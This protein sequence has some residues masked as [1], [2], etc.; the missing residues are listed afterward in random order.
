VDRIEY[1]IDGKQV[2]AHEFVT[3]SSR[4]LELLASLHPTG[5]FDPLIADLRT[6]STIEAFEL[7][8]PASGHAADEALRG[9]QLVRAG[10]RPPESWDPSTAKAAQ[11][12]V[13][14]GKQR[15]STCHLRLIASNGQTMRHVAIDDQIRLA[16][17]EELTLTELYKYRTSLAGIIKGI[18]LSQ[19]NRARLK[20]D[21]GDS[22]NVS[23]PSDLFEKFRDGL[24]RRVDVFGLVRERPDFSPQHIAAEE[25][26]I[27]GE[28]FPSWEAFF[29]ISPKH[30]DDPDHVTYIRRL[31]EH[32]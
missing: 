12:F 13:N 30:P 27:L 21:R 25:I 18:S 5:E 1:K 2:G 28:G 4:L 15:S 26:T 14:T 8:D 32:D 20:T 29:G 22:I 10:K 16:F 6:G 17:K 9:L 31:R 3:G 19:G 7:A 11:D 24:G 23:F